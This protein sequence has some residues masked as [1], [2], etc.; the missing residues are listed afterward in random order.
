MA[1]LRL[2]IFPLVLLG[3]GSCKTTE[4]L[5]YSKAQP[6]DR[7]ILGKAH[8]YLPV[9]P[10]NTSIL[11]GSM[12][13]RR[14]R[15]WEIVYEMIKPVPV[16]TEFA[17]KTGIEA[18]RLPLWQTFYE[19][20][21]YLRMFESL[22]EALGDE[23][24][25]VRENGNVELDQAGLPKA[26]DF[27]PT[28]MEEVFDWHASK[29][30]AYTFPPR[31]FNQRL[32]QL[33]NQAAIEGLSG[34]GLTLFSPGLLYHYFQNYRRVYQCDKAFV[35]DVPANN[36]GLSDSNFTRCFAAEFPSGNTNLNI[37]SSGNYASGCS[38]NQDGCDGGQDQDC[39][40]RQIG[41]S[42][43][44]KTSWNLKQAGSKLGVFDTSAEN[45]EKILGEGE[46]KTDDFI[47]PSSRGYSD[48]YTVDALT[49]DNQ[50]FNSFQLMAQNS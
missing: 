50:T 28:Q 43:A 7:K 2:T 33:K 17:R 23:D 46:W 19:S 12:A 34:T 24:R 8:A 4:P 39:S 15:A 30:L 35:G 21:E 40:Q 6:Q 45:M 49:F 14:K 37:P 38:Y 31:R 20:S 32:G 36:K 47:D 25:M 1:G 26:A 3:V 18:P 44:I 22:Y 42:V 16:D 13:E 11:N 9:G 5:T 29:R 10:D 27:C 41:G 48:I